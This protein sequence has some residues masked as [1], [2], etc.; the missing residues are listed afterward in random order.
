[1]IKWSLFRNFTANNP[2]KR[3]ERKVAIEIAITVICLEDLKLLG[4]LII[5]KNTSLAYRQA[6]FR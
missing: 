2:P 3:V 4:S 1:M 5:T 6:G